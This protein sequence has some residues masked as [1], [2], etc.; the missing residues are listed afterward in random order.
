ATA[1]EDV[2][3]LPNSRISNS[4]ETKSSPESEDISLET[5]EVEAALQ[6]P[7]SD[8]IAPQVLPLPPNYPPVIYPP[9]VARSQSPVAQTTNDMLVDSG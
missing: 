6:L 8:E 2:V 5:A 1:N 4:T 7:S 3:D 9:I